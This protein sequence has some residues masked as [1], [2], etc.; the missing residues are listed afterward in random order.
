MNLFSTKTVAHLIFSKCVSWAGLCSP[1]GLC[2]PFPLTAGA[3][4]RNCYGRGQS[5]VAALSFF[6]PFH[7]LQASLREFQCIKKG[8]ADAMPSSI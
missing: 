7:S 5:S 6:M 8:I 3:L 2:I 4:S 1:C